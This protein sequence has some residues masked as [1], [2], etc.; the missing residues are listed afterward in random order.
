MATKT[1]NKPKLDLKA[2][3]QEVWDWYALKRQ[4]MLLEPKLKNGTNRFKDLL[5]IY[6]EKDPTDGSIYL[7]LEEPLGDQRIQFLKNLCVTQSNVINTEV[8]E[9]ILTE[10]GLWEELTEVV[11]VPDEAR[12]SAAYYDNKITDDEF[13]RM[14][15]KT[16]S[17]RFFLLD[18]DRKPVRA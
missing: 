13:A 11:R 5:G 14:F 16:T 6:G 17:Y 3:R 2:L 1:K 15:P 8:A 18:E 7:D 9:E 4:S 10:K 12:I